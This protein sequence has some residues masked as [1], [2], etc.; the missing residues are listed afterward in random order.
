MRI[1]TI[2]PEFCLHEGIYD[3]EKASGL[4][5]R[6]AFIGLWM[7]ADKAGRFAWRPRMLKHQILPYDAVDFGQVMDALAANGF[8]IRYEID[9]NAFGCIPSWAKH[10]RP[11]TDE[12]ESVLPQPPILAVTNP[13]LRSDEPASGQILGK[14]WN[15]EGNREG[16]GEGDARGAVVAGT[17]HDA[18]VATDGVAGATATDDGPERTQEA[19]KPT[20][21]C[22]DSGEPVKTPP[23][24][25][26]ARSEPIQDTE[27]KLVL[28]QEEPDTPT[29]G[30]KAPRRPAFARPTLEEVKLMAAKSGLPE[31]EAVRF[32][33]HFEA[34]GWRVGGRTPMKSVPAA[35]TKWR[36]NWEDNCRANGSHRNGN[37]QS[38][39]ADR[40]HDQ[41]ALEH[42]K[43]EMARLSGPAEYDQEHRKQWLAA[44]AKAD[45]ITKRLYG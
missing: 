25:N 29:N 22:D 7:A 32:H 5:L 24:A 36:M 8:V 19:Q 41:K 13:H 30:K 44:K 26:S 4:P 34:N 14:E 37:A 31:R 28:G 23:G 17:G 1:R 11:R 10:Q 43:S 9:G 35:L 45:E 3:A 27:C 33:A 2:K 16:N 21:Q 15:R 42:W 38:Q 40:I 18:P 6:L 39:V 20:V 12:P